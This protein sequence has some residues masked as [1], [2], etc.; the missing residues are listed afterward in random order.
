VVQ[1]C[2][3]LLK[4]TQKSIIS[5]LVS[6]QSDYDIKTFQTELELW[7]AMIKEE[8]NLLL[9]QKVDEEAG[10]NSRF[11][12]FSNKSSEVALL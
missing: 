6:S 9:A 3:R 1:V 2:H 7:S 8:V 10:E 4:I 11:R 5:Q 12:A